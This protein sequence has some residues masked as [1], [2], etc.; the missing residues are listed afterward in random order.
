MSL[1]AGLARIAQTTPDRLSVIRELD[2]REE[3]LQRQLA[4]LRLLKETLANQTLTP[5]DDVQDA[6]ITAGSPVEVQTQCLLCGKTLFCGVEPI[7]RLGTELVFKDGRPVLSS[8]FCTFVQ[9][10]RHDHKISNVNQ[11]GE[12][13]YQCPLG[14]GKKDVKCG[15]IYTHLLSEIHHGKNNKHFSCNQCATT[16]RDVDAAKKHFREQHQMPHIPIHRAETRTRPRSISNSNRMLSSSIGV[17]RLSTSLSQSVQRASLPESLASSWGSRFG[18][19]V[20]P[21]SIYRDLPTSPQSGPSS[22]PSL[23]EES[24]DLS[25]FVDWEGGDASKGMM[26]DPSHH[27]N[28]P[29]TDSSGHVILPHMLSNM[30]LQDLS[31]GGLVPGVIAE[32]DL[33]SQLSQTSAGVG[34]DQTSAHL[35][36]LSR[37]AKSTPTAALSLAPAHGVGDM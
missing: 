17:R 28:L 10:F 19:T 36:F 22:A 21:V 37:S 1:S 8:N 5:R 34:S 16:L 4:E 30:T 9:H 24:F 20:S 11:A 35:R 25:E 23:P 15:N 27:P 7:T 3:M 13:P 26:F 14:C 33:R 29:V 6:M 18:S 32:A 2:E 31:A 12:K